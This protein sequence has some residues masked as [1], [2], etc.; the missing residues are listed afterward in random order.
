MALGLIGD[1]KTMVKNLAGGLIFLTIFVV[2]ARVSGWSP[3]NLILGPQFDKTKVQN[4][5]DLANAQSIWWLPEYPTLIK[6]IDSSPSKQ[7]ETSYRNWTVG[8]IKNRFEANQK[9]ECHCP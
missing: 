1:M 7:I 8:T 3:L 2:L 6:K 4:G 9:T 5:H